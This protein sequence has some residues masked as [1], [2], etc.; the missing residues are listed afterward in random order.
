MTLNRFVMHSIRDDEN[1]RWNSFVDIKSDSLAGGKIGDIGYVACAHP[2]Y[3]YDPSKPDELRDGLMVSVT[4]LSINNLWGAACDGDGNRWTKWGEIQP[5]IGSNG[6]MDYVAACNGQWGTFYLLFRNKNNNLLLTFREIT[7]EWGHYESVPPLPTGTAINSIA[8]E[9]SYSMLHVLAVDTSGRL[10][11]IMREESKQWTDW[12]YINPPISNGVIRQ[13]AA[14]SGS[15]NNNSTTGQLQVCAVI[16]NPNNPGTL[17]HIIR[18]NDNSWGSWGNVTAAASVGWPIYSIACDLKD[19]SGDMHV[20]AADKTRLFHT[21]RLDN[22][23]WT[24]L[25]QVDELP[26]NAMKIDVL[27]CAKA[28]KKLHVCV[29]YYTCED[30]DNGICPLK[31]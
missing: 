12:I 23:T 14:C 4:D 6:R 25:E 28:I 29:G 3:P 24:R 10:L 13:V 16:D 9:F 30:W 2:P 21:I 17:W 11:Y 22:G 26:K 19:P 8:C 18:K 1:S 5:Q 7:G 15:T 20:L 31:P 27:A